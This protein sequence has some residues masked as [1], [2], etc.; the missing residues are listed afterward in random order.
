MTPP[1]ITVIEHEADCPLDRFSSWLG[2]PVE[3]VRPYAGQ[4]V[5]SSVP[6]GLIVLG[7]EMNAYDDAA[8]WLPAVRDLLKVSVS[9]GVPTL[10]ICLGAQLLAV[11]CGGKVSVDADP[12]RESGVIDV[13][14]LPAAIDDPLCSG[15]G[16]AGP[17]LHRDAISA[18]P[19]GAVLL[20][21]SSMYPHQ[22]FRLGS[23]AWGVQFHPEVS[24]ATLRLWAEEAPDVDTAAVVDAFVARDNEVQAVGRALARR[25][26]ELVYSAPP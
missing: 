5:P 26:G 2:V 15:L 10:G 20:G 19:P 13:D 11:A 1:S 24:L 4:P 18:L 3:I 25:F 7:G 14:W 12:G 23:S 8:P 16:S 17:S 21:S 22:A 6:S 9:S